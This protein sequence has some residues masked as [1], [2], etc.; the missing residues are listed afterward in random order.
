MGELSLEGEWLATWG[1]GLHAKF[2]H[3]FQPVE[4]P[5]RYLQMIRRYSKTHGCIWISWME[6]PR[7]LSTESGL[8]NMRTPIDPLIS[9]SALLPRPVKMSW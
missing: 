3:A 1:D 7:L 5:E 8:A 9:I 6:L 2:V 4:D